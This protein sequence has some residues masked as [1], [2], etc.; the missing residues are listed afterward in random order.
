MS[1]HQRYHS[2]AEDSKSLSPVGSS[3]QPPGHPISLSTKS[4]FSLRH[5]GEHS[6]PGFEVIRARREYVSQFFDGDALFGPS[7]PLMSLTEGVGNILAAP[8]NFRS[9]FPSALSL[10]VIVGQDFAVPGRLMLPLPRWFGALSPSVP[11][12]VGHFLTA[13]SSFRLGVSGLPLS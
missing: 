1:R 8:D 6:C 12:G 2:V 7:N 9:P 5:F 3:V 11:R 4:G 10:T 13:P